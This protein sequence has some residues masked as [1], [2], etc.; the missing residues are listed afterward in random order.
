MSLSLSSRVAAVLLST[1]LALGA[2]ACKDSEQAAASKTV[3]VPAGGA[4][5][6]ALRERVT[7]YW[8]TRAAGNLHT[9]YPFYEPAFRERYTA[10]Q[11]AINFSRLNRFAPV[12]LGIDSVE[13]DA[14]KARARVTVKLRAKVDMLEGAEIEAPT[15]ETWALEG[16]NWWRQAEPLAPSF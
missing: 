1:C 9:G 4:S 15:S 3:D 10:D 2:G 13:I 6:E 14:E 12:M 8:K 11:F 7:L 16:G 5:E